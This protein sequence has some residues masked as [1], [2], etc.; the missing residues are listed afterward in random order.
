MKRFEARTRRCENSSWANGKQSCA[1]GLLIAVWSYKLCE[2]PDGVTVRA[3][4]CAQ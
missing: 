2:W 1:I 4:L 3:M